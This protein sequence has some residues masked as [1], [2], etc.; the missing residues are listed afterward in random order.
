[1][2]NGLDATLANSSLTI[3][4][5]ALYPGTDKAINL[6]TSSK[7]WGSIYAS[8]LILTSTVDA[9][10]GSVT[11]CGITIGAT[12][13]THLLIDNNEILA[14]TAADTTGPLY[15]NNNLTVYNE[16]G[17]AVDIAGRADMGCLL[18]TNTG[19]TG[20]GTGGTSGLTAVTGRVYFKLI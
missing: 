12:S 20:Y 14:K 19:W 9:A 17:P 5:S 7:H 11:N 15:L 10:P 2:P 16:Q 4:A 1:V 13:G 6:G 8:R 3:D 18:L